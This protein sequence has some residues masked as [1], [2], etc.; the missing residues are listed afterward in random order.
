M[1]KYNFDGV[2]LPNDDDPIVVKSVDSG[3][4][5]NFDGVVLPND[6]DPDVVQTKKRFER[7]IDANSD[8]SRN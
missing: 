6:D 5:Y 2:V 7:T 4:K 1:K 3:K 8:R